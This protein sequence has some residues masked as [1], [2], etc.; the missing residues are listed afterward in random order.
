MIEI[1][2]YDFMRNALMAGI[3]ASIICGIIGVLV[4]LKKI[5]FISGGIAHSSFAGI[6]LAIL[7]KI[8]PITPTI[9]VALICA[10]IIGFLKKVTHI[11]EDTAI[12]ILWAIGMALG[13][14][15]ISLSPTYPPDLFSYL[16][17]NIL[18]VSSSDLIIIS[19]I[20]LF[21]IIVF[22]LFYKEFIILIFDEEFG[23]ASGIPITLLY[24]LLL[25]QVALTII[26]LMKIVGIILVIALLTI[27]TA[28]GKLLSNNIPKM[29]LLSIAFSISSVF[30]GL[31]FSY[32]FDISSGA[33]IILFTSFVFFIVFISKL[34]FEKIKF[35]SS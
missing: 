9:L 4:I 2:Q 34:I 31:L 27:P 25:N 10:T 29:I 22:L 23:L 5:V 13:I 11:K 14:L 12:G 24:F 7:L 32:Y 1:F 33:S 21:I 16:F 35:F 6:G 28:T 18:S 15:F 30:F 26:I 17:G 3:L 20:S 8:N 19:I